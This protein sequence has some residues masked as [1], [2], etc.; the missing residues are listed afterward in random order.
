[1]VYAQIS[2]YATLINEG[3]D[4]FLAYR[5][6]LG[7]IS[8]SLCLSVPMLCMMFLVQLCLMSGE[9]IQMSAK[10]SLIFETADLEQASP[11]TVSRYP[12]AP[13]EESTLK[14]SGLYN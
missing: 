14:H 9:I 7:L 2:S 1:M 6:I 8:L 4:G 13:I 5:R 12:A 10:M 11:A 3:P